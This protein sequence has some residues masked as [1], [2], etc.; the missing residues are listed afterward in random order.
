ML[1]SVKLHQRGYIVQG[2][3]GMEV[4]PTFWMA[5]PNTS[6][7]GLDGLKRI[8]IEVVLFS[9]RWDCSEDMV[10]EARNRVLARLRELI[11]EQ[12]PGIQL[13]ITYLKCKY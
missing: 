11:E 7:W 1:T 4:S 9:W 12:H 8:E 3:E 10:N 13:L 5:I 6:S 2:A